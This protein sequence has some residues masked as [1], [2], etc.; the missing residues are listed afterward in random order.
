MICD[1]E[2]I[3]NDKKK[4]LN[5]TEGIITFN[6][7]NGIKKE[8]ISNYFKIYVG[9]VS[10]YV[11]MVTTGLPPPPTGGQPFREPARLPGAPR[12]ANDV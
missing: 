12:A 10:G 8:K 2:T 1:S 7:D 5:N 6:D 3:Y 4:I 9:M 11:R